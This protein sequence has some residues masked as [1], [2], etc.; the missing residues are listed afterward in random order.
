MS[1]MYTAQG[2]LLCG[3]EEQGTQFS[4]TVV[5]NAEPPNASM[6]HSL[7]SREQFVQEDKNITDMRKMIQSALKRPMQ[8]TSNNT[9]SLK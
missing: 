3:S 1:C 4:S 5:R 9:L 6:L 2:A 8:K 7:E